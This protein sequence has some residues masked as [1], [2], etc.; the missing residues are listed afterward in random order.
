MRRTPI[1]LVNPAG[2]AHVQKHSDTAT[3][4]VAA[5]AEKDHCDRRKYPIKHM[6]THHHNNGD[7]CDRDILQVEVYMAALATRPL[8][9]W[10]TL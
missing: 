1:S 7:L 9:L 10:R 6:H 5:A 8:T 4:A 2:V 3:R